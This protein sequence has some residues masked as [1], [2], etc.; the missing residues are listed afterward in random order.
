MAT[1]D[2][3]ELQPIP[4][5]D[6]KPAGSS[7]ILIWLVMLSLAGFLLPLY[8]IYSTLKQDNQQLEVE[9]GNIEATLSSTP[10]RSPE[11]Q[12]LTDLLLQLQQQAI[13]VEEARATLDA[14]HVD[15]PATMA[16]LG[17]YDQS[18]MALNSLVQTGDQITINGQANHENAIMVYLAALQT[19]AHFERVSI[20]SVTMISSSDTDTATP[21]QPVMPLNFTIQVVLK[22]RADS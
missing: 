1:L 7:R 15:W 14:S 19:S 16:V 17:S 9:R 6:E 21:T 10:E 22:M 13:M 12:E 11:E 4:E 18:Q 8:L 3:A 20:L 5:T 2:M